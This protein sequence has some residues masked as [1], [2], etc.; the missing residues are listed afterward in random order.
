MSKHWIPD[1]LPLERPSP[2]RIYDCVLG[3]YHNFEQDRAVAARLANLY[4]D[5]ALAAQANRG[6]LRR[7]VQFLAK[8]GCDQFLDLG[9]GL[10]TVGN[11][12]EVAQGVSPDAHVVYVD[13]DPVAVAH[14]RVILAD[15]PRTVT[16]QGDMRQPALILEHEEVRAFLDLERPLGLLAVVALHYVV[17][18]DL[19]GEAMDLLRARLAPGSWLVIAHGIPEEQSA[20][21]STGLKQMFQPASS[22]RS[23]PREGILRFF[24]DWQLVEPGLVY[25]P[26]WRPE[27]AD[28]VLLDQPG[29]GLTLAGVAKKPMPDGW[30]G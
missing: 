12:H 25:V 7:A 21:G 20:A 29:R 30:R 13:I 8:D 4:P 9:S 2:A 27:G 19:A 3:G 1:D 6:F 5:L 28:D 26:L 18:D 24:G 15:D 23:R 11:V 10:P 22:T 14:G 16:I 17:E